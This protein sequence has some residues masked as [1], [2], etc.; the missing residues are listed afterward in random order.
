MSSFINI[1]YPAEHPGVA[2]FESALDSARQIRRGFDGSKGLAAM[3]LAALV[4]AMMVVADQ[5]VENWADGHLLV[6]WVALWAVAF[7][8]LALFAGTARQLA[9][10]MVAALDDWS[11]S[12]AR[13]RADMRMWEAAK[14]DPRVMSDLRVA[15]L[16]AESSADEA[17]AQPQA[18]DVTVAAPA[19]LSRRA[20]RLGGAELRAYQRNSI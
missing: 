5:V 18:A 11:S 16:R 2:R 1:Q 14:A 20:L 13:G 6:V 15:M 19:G 3:L 10:R 9:A 17:L 8:A 4:A 12:V 7:A